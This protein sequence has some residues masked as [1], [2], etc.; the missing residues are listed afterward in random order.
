MVAPNLQL[1]LLLVSF[2]CGYPVTSERQKDPST[3]LNKDLTYHAETMAEPQGAALNV[4]LIALP[5]AGHMSPSLALGEELVRRGHNVTLLTT[6]DPAAEEKTMAK[7]KVRGMTYTS[8]GESVIAAELA[9]KAR[10]RKQDVSTL[11]LVRSLMILLPQEVD[12]LGKYLDR[13]LA[14]N[15]VDIMVGEEFVEP[16]LQCL[17]VQ[18]NIKTVLLST[19]LQ[20]QPHTLPHWPWPN[21]MAGSMSDNLTFLQRLK[22]TVISVAFQFLHRNMIGRFMLSSVQAYCPSVTLTQA[23]AASGVY[24]PQIVP[25]V[26]GFEYPRTISPLT[27]YVGPL[28]TKDPDPIFAD[29]QEWLDS[30]EKQS[31]VYVSMGSHVILGKEKG[32]AILSGVLSTNYS[33]LWSLRESNHF[34]LDGVEL[35]ENRVR[36]LNWAPQLAV[37]GH[38][39]IRIAIVHGGI[40]GVYESLYNEVPLIVL[41]GGGDQMANA[42]RVHHQGLGIHLQGSDITESGVI[43]AIKKIDEG[44]YR[45]NV[46][47]LKK[48]FVD[49]GGRE[50]AAELIEF[51]AE[52]GYSHLVPAYAKYDWSWVQYYNVDVYLALTLLLLLSCCLTIKC[53]HCTCRLI[54]CSK[55]NKEKSD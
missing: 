14:T 38:R 46:Q 3:N 48:S 32:A 18:R 12:T 50:R 45:E 4:L 49:A 25:S 42:G 36:I 27:T 34:I 41:P 40:N 1:L 26:I 43:E 28:L 19:T 10:S 33:L 44:A 51:Y 11:E 16:V 8:A 52:I 15:R 9:A 13:Y 2:F 31:V 30:K 6:T 54:L 7:V 24:I 37:L 35:D 20:V 53:C 22:L 55:L 47:R 21:M 29:L 39:A 5:A 23:T 17:G